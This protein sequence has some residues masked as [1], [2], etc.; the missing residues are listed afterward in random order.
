MRTMTHYVYKL[1][2]P[3]TFEFYI[4][5]RTCNGDAVDDTEYMGSMA[6][7]NPDKSKLVKTILDDTFS[8]RYDANLKEIELLQEY[9]DNPLNRNYHIPSVGFCCLGLPKSEEHRENLSKSRKLLFQLNPTLIE[10]NRIIQKK[11]WESDEVR[12]EQRKR[13]TLINSTDEYREKQRN[14]AK[15]KCKP[16]LQFSKSGEFI[17]EYESIHSAGRTLNVDKTCISRNC[18]NRYKSAFGYVWK[19]KS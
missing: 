5:V 14:S 1:E 17:A 11:R 7:W 9:I 10:E 13:M 6:T 19:Y 2:N 18:N 4:G 15:D 8:T 3:N 16:V 12:N